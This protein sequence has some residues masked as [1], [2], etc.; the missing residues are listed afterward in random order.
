[1]T[2]T[3]NIEYHTR[4]GESLALVAGDKEYPMA[5]TSDGIWLL[6]LKGQSA[7]FLEDYFYVVIEEGIWT[8]TEWSHHHRKAGDGKHEICD[9]WIDCPIAGCP[10]PKEHSA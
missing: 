4:W 8:R 5:Y 7:A 9:A 6:S 10:F 2:L 3:F 1:M